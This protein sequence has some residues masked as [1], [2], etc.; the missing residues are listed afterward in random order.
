MRVLS[1][2]LCTLIKHLHHAVHGWCQVEEDNPCRMDWLTMK[3]QQWIRPWIETSAWQSFPLVNSVSPTYQSA[4]SSFQTIWHL[5]GIVFSLLVCFV[6]LFFCSVCF[7]LGPWR[8]QLVLFLKG[9]RTE[10][11]NSGFGDFA[12]NTLC[13]TPSACTWQWT[14]WGLTTG[15]SLSSW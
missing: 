8:R 15:L 2:V 12:A 11:G 5:P 3:G 7:L 6:F 4:G 1:F 13:R 10:T 14:C 9:W